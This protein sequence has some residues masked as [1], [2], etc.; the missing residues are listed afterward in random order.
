MQVVLDTKVV[1]GTE[2][3]QLEK[4]GENEEADREREEGEELV[5]VHSPK[6][7]VGQYSVQQPLLPS[8]NL[9]SVQMDCWFYNCCYAEIKVETYPHF[10]GGCALLRHDTRCCMCVLIRA[11]P[12][13]TGTVERE[14]DMSRVASSWNQLGTRPPAPSS[15]T[16]RK[17]RPLQSQ[18]IP[19]I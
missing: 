4:E 9:V 14:R 12:L 10:R 11:H 3:K 18:T 13:H 7:T 17:A 19:E 15:E 5:Y 6:K 16:S 1:T 2:R 8:I